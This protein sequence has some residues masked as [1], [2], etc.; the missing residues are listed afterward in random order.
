MQHNELVTFPSCLLELPSL[1]ELNLSCNKLN[2]IPYVSNW[3][4]YLSVL[5]LSENLLENLELP[6]DILAPS[7]HT[8]NLSR[9]NLIKLPACIGSFTNLRCFDIS[10]NPYILSL[11]PEMGELSNLEE[12]NVDGL[13]DLSDPPIKIQKDPQECI[14]YLKGKLYSMNKLFQMKLVVVGEKDSGKTPLVARLQGHSDILPQSTVGIDLSEW[15]YKRKYH[16]SIWKL[17]GEINCRAVQQCFMS[18]N[19]MYLVVW[20]LAHFENGIEEIEV[21]LNII[22]TNAPQSCVLIVGT[23]MDRVEKPIVNEILNKVS[24][25]AMTYHDRLYIPVSGILTVGLTDNIA[26]L[27]EAILTQALSF[28]GRDN[29]PLMGQDIP[30]DHF[31]LI[32]LI[33]SL[34]EDVEKECRDPV[35]NA[36]QLKKLLK[37]KKV[38]AMHKERVFNRAIAF[39]NRAGVLLHSEDRINRLND[40]Y[41]VDP[42]WLL[43]VMS[44]I[45]ESKDLANNGILQKKHL[46]S[47]FQDMILPLEYFDGLLTFLDKFE[48]VFPLACSSCMLIPSL[49]SDKKPDNAN[50][51]DNESLQLYSRYIILECSMPPGFWARFISKTMCLVKQIHLALNSILKHDS[52]NNSHSLFLNKN[53]SFKEEDTNELVPPSSLQITFWKEGIVCKEPGLFFCVESLKSISTHQTGFVFK[54]LPTKKSIQILFQLYDILLEVIS[55][56]YPTLNKAWNTSDMHCLVPCY[57]CGDLDPSY[58][59]HFNVNEFLSIDSNTNHPFITCGRDESPDKNHQVDLVDIIPDYLFQ[60]IDTHLLNSD[61]INYRDSI[62]TNGTFGMSYQGIYESKS[63]VV[64]KYSNFSMDESRALRTEVKML[65]RAHPCLVQLVGVLKCSCIYDAGLVFEEAPLGTLDDIIK[66]STPLPRLVIFRITAQ[67]TAALGFLHKHSIVFR[68][69]TTASVLIWS[70]NASALCHAKLKG[71]HNAIH[72]SSIGTLGI[73]ESNVC[74]PAPEMYHVDDN[75]IR[76]TYNYKVDIFSLGMLL[77]QLIACRYPYYDVDPHDVSLKVYQGERPNISEIPL[78][79]IGYYYLAYLMEECWKHEPYERP[80]TS[81]VISFVSNVTFQSLMGIYF[82]DI[83]PSLTQGCAVSPSGNI[84]TNS[85]LWMCSTDSDGIKLSIYEIDRMVRMNKHS[86]KDKVVQCMCVCDNH[87]WICSKRSNTDD[88]VID[89]TKTVLQKI[90]VIHSLN[91]KS[92]YVTCITSSEDSVYVGTLRGYCYIFDKDIKLL[93][94]EYNEPIYC[95]VSYD[96]IDGIVVTDRHV[97]VSHSRFVSFLNLLTLRCEHLY[98][99]THSM[100]SYIGQLSKSTYEDTN[101]IWSAC[102][103]GQVI[104]AWIAET[105]SHLYD[106]MVSD[107]LLREDG[108]NV[109]S[110]HLEDNSDGQLDRNEVVISCMIPVL[111]TVWVGMSTGHILVFHEQELMIYVRPY[112][113]PVRF[114]IPIACQELCQFTVISSGDYFTPPLL[115]YADKQVTFIGKSGVLILWEAYSAMTIYQMKALHQKGPTYLDNFQTIREM[116]RLLQFD[117]DT[118]VLGNIPGMLDNEIPSLEDLVTIPKES[119]AESAESFSQQRH[120]QLYNEH[121]CYKNA[122]LSQ[123]Q[124]EKEPI[125]RNL[126]NIDEVD[127]QQSNHNTVDIDV[128]GTSHNTDILSTSTHPFC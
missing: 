79:S 5:D 107:V 27:Q 64:K 43:K 108:D 51:C 18:D 22:A 2:Q 118:S 98:K 32:K 115:E 124:L 57:K 39:L 44:K 49:M 106:I 10:H 128:Q 71:S 82:D 88:G 95:S 117:D 12:L 120:L 42:R 109:H 73:V 23:I 89:I 4:R 121:G 125:K 93:V 126:Q 111:D 36:E 104:S 38:L 41:I 75:G 100:N 47:L 66:K 77:Y 45:I 26:V 68:E 46:C 6:N 7:L 31:K 74:F 21:W 58:A 13:I 113:Q 50:I 62:I 127:S 116:I 3:S 11:P 122:S 105:G 35:M 15:H 67:I 83:C 59:F 54:A 85:E 17:G 19:S 33:E 56:R 37:E 30:H 96:R 63:I 91:L 1:K 80:E 70:I 72:V 81:T 86:L 119:R 102:V 97:W 29:S 103:G 110:I 60:D 90:H 114:L 87:V 34:Q 112:L 123:T 84:K 99:R 61:D 94:Q 69:L 55:E 53:P 40:L 24:E 76:G 14:Q 48:M 101:I 28:K 20:N 65:E 9:N 8:L 16:F 52:T 25:I 92:D 78:A